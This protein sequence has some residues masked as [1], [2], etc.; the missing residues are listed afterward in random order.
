MPP[1]RFGSHEYNRNAKERNSTNRGLE[2]SNIL[3]KI[4][5]FILNLLFPAEG[6]TFVVVDAQC[7]RDCAS[8]SAIVVRLDAR[9]QR[10]PASKFPILR[11]AATTDDPSPPSVVAA[12]RTW[13]R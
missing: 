6:A 7:S 10:A 4:N 12:R 8:T 3:Y 11:R 13:V 1:S 2:P 5:I 9:R